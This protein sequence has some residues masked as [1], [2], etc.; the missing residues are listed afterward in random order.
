M[1]YQK[2][3]KKKNNLTL[4][5]SLPSLPPLPPSWFEF[6]SSDRP[7]QSFFS[8]E[9]S[10]PSHSPHFL[11][12]SSPACASSFCPHFLQQPAY[13]LPPSVSINAGLPPNH[14][15]ATAAFPSAT[16]AS[17]SISS[18]SGDRTAARGQHFHRSS[19]P[20]TTPSSPLAD[21][22]H[23]R[24]SNTD[25]PSASLSSPISSSPSTP[26]IPPVAADTRRP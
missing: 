22:Q 1:K 17:P 10:S 2:N 9:Q 11:L 14:Q 25:R 13:L 12:S 16:A 5:L 8:T 18:P 4:N 3:T 7:G 26:K 21:D 15:P 23:H 20:S 19:K 6:F 24:R